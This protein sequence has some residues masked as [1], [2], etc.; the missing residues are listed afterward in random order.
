M[1]TLMH[2]GG[3]LVACTAAVLLAG[4]VVI[5][6]FSGGS[7]ELKATVIQGKG[8]AKI[9]WLPVTGFI[10][11]QPKSRAFGLMHEP[12][13]LARVSSAL[14]KAKHDK[15]IAA[16]ILRI[17]SPGGSVAASDEIYA[18]IQRF[19][20]NSDVPVIA[21]F[22]SLAASG[23]YYIAMAA[24]Y[25]IAQPTT[26]TGSIGVILLNFDASD[27]LH[28][29]GISN[30]SYVSGPNKDLLS[31]LK[32]DSP[33]QRQIMDG[34]IDH[35]YQR[36]VY[37]VRTNRPEL[38]TSQIDRITD[39]RVF[40]ADQALKLGLID[41]IGHIADAIDA[42]RKRAGVSHARVIRY[43]R[44]KQPPRNLYAHASL[45]GS[46]SAAAQVNI[47]PINLG[48]DALSG[49]SLLYLWRPGR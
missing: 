27:L 22:G 13:T 47:L 24:D 8:D 30:E 20:K 1:R 4:C 2:S 32:H 42:A 41:A 36:F 5:T 38:D 31:P 29:L 39:G 3:L 18:R 33:E 45:G 26:V 21:S 14:D 19:K 6:P 11:G 10:S 15:D 28:K 16:V 44:G 46:Q 7:N 48:L 40:T 34:V 9:L 12:S 25:I 35:L 43:Y 37:V 23:A 49:P 17:D